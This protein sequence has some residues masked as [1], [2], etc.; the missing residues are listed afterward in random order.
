MTPVIELAR[1]LAL[2]EELEAT[3]TFDR[4]R[5]LGPTPALAPDDALDLTVALEHVGYHRLQHQRRQL[6]RGEKADNFLD[7]NELKRA[8]L[9]ISAHQDGLR[10]RFNTGSMG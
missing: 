1:V 5:A 3:N 7:P 8:F 6:D 4:L 2:S 10:R 9:T